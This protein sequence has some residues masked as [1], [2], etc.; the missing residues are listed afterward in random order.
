MAEPEAGSV[1]KTVAK[2][3]FALSDKDIQALPFTRSGSSKLYSTLNVQAAA[4]QKYGSVQAAYDK[5]AHR[6]S[7]K[8]S[9]KRK[10]DAEEV[11]TNMLYCVCY[12]L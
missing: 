10:R 11:R 6:A 1:A 4:V 7:T 3:R 9:R 8:V 12:M 5:A 2:E